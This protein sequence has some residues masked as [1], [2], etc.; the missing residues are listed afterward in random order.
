[1]K[2]YLSI[3]AFATML[4]TTSA[5]STDVQH[6][7]QAPK[8]E[9]LSPHSSLSNIEAPEFPGGII[10]FRTKIMNFFHASAVR[11]EGRVQAESTFVIEKDGSVSSIKVFGENP[12]MN[13][14]LT[15]VLQLLS[16][17]KWTPAKK[18]GQPIRYKY[19]LPVKVVLE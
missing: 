18:D 12:T 1:M 6:S 13:A 16:T 10:A 4:S 9:L 11:G 2:H 3:L 7:L 14:E 15:R 5:Q 17:E 19:T 8:T